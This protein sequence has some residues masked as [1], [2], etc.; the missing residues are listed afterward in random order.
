MPS[1]VTHGVSIVRI[2]QKIDHVITALHCFKS[3][4]VFTEFKLGRDWI[5]TNLTLQRDMDVQ[6]F[7]VVIRIL[8]GFMSAY[9]LSD[10]RVFLHKAVSDALKIRTI[11]HAQDMWELARSCKQFHLLCLT[12]PCNLPGTALLSAFQSS[13]G[14]FKPTG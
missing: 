11:C 1:R 7:E 9:H 4:F 10:D 2:S 13:R 12:D 5:A 14:A 6:L 3:D 8:G